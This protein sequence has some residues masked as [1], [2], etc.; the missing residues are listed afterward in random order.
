ME[1]VSKPYKVVIAGGRDF[2]DY[3]LL[4][5]KCD[6]LLQ[7]HKRIEIVSGCANGADSLGERYASEHNYPIK[8]FRANWSELG[9]AAGY[10]RNEVMAEYADAVICFWDGKSKGTEHMINLANKHLK[11]VRVINY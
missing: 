8:Q 3:K 6:L 5:S 4:K 7:N 9:K 1:E 2:A 10:I 11:P